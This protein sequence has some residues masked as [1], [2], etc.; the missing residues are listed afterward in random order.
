MK[1][2]D[3]TGMSVLSHGEDIAN[4]RLLFENGCVANVTVSRVSHDKLRQIRLFQQDAY[5]ILDYQHQTGEIFRYHNGTTTKEPLEIEKG[6]PLKREVESFIRCCID[7]VKPR[8]SGH[9]AAAALELAL[10]IT[11]RIEDFT[12][13][14]PFGCIGEP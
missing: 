8:V 6:E 7:G 5:L 3:A 4:A 10:E 14:P 12:F 13:P 9:E 11:R 2:I 1:S